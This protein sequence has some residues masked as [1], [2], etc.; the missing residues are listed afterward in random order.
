VPIEIDPLAEALDCLL[1]AEAAAD[2]LVDVDAPAV[3]LDA[4]LVGELEASVEVMEREP[5]VVEG[6]LET[7]EPPIDVLIPIFVLK[8]VEAESAYAAWPRQVPS[9][10][11]GLVGVSRL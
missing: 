3:E 1:E 4:A 8:L 11:S 6:E 10:L 9:T 2:S 5:E 7:E